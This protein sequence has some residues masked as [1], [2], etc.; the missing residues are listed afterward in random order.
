MGAAALLKPGTQANGPRTA[1]E[2]MGEAVQQAVDIF[3]AAAQLESQGYGDSVAQQ[4]GYRD[5]FDLAGG[6]M[7]NTRSRRERRSPTGVAAML[8]AALGRML[9]LFSGVVIS[10][11]VLPSAT[12]PKQMFVAGAVGWLCGQAVS[13]GIWHG[14]GTAKPLAAGTSLTCAPVVLGLAAIV[15]WGIDSW[16]PLLWALWAVAASVLVIM[17]PGFKVVLFASAGAAASWV[18]GQYFHG[19]GVACAI[20][21]ILLACVGAARVVHQDGGFLSR[22]S[23]PMVAAQLMG[24]AQAAG[25]IVTLG[26]VLFIIGPTVFVAVAIGGL[27][28]GAL[29]D[30]ILELVQAGVRH[31]AAFP[32][33]LNTGRLVTALV[34]IIGAVTVIA[35]ALLTATVVRDMFAPGEALW[36]I[37]LATALV[38]AV[39]AGTG[40]LLRAGTAVGAL[41]LATGGAAFALLG[42]GVVYFGIHS[43]IVIILF[44]LSVLSVL[45]TSWLAARHMSQPAA[46]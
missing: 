17:R 6:L 25:Q 43:D 19:A 10:L 31:L 44:A 38:A 39:T 16:A 2:H 27:V 3:D 29:S 35:A 20:L 23:G 34:G 5:V 28:A 12:S 33:T 7:A 24:A 46:W 4:S 22:P 21:V 14:L 9:V 8:L 41:L 40:L 30:P 18:I 26:M 13:A 42:G 15:S 37:M 11:A 1:V 32:F 36:P 45:V